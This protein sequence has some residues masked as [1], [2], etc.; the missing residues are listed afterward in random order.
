MERANSTSFAI[1]TQIWDTH[2]A[3]LAEFLY[4]R[5]V[6]PQGG[7]V[8]NIQRTTFENEHTLSFRLIDPQGKWHLDT[9]IKVGKTVEVKTTPSDETRPPQQVLDR[10]KDDIFIAVELFEEQMRR[11]TIYFAWNEGTKVTSEKSIFRRKRVL[12]KI[13]FQNMIF[14]LMLSLILSIILFVL[15]QPIFGIYV[16]VAL[17]AAQFLMV[18]AA[19]NLISGGADWTVTKQNP[20]VHILMYMVPPEE[21]QIFRQKLSKDMLRKIKTEIYQNTLAL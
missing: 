1:Q 9:E 13:L 5:L 6:L 16:P 12:D 21:A 2:I 10:F 20:N 11:R 19:P 17:I 14:L 3:E 4:Q 15:L 7:S 8:I 18:L